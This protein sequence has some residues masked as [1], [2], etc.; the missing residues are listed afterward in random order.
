MIS[1]TRMRAELAF[2]VQKGQSKEPP[3][4]VVEYAEA[5]AAVLEKTT[6]LRAIR[7]ALGAMPQTRKRKTSPKRG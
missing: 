3:K 1:F 6:R 4:A 2:L 5:Q 7:V